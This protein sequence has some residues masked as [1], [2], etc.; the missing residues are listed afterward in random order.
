MSAPGIKL[1]VTQRYALKDMTLE[2]SQ[3]IPAGRVMFCKGRKIL[4]FGDVTDLIRARFIAPRADTLCLSAA[5]YDDVKAW[6][7]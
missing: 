3:A 6:I 7:G 2:K 1:S 5:D 4:A